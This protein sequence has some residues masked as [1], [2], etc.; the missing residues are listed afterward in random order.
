M[1]D[2]DVLASDE[3]IER[4]AT[5]QDVEADNVSQMLTAWRDENA[6][7]DRWAVRAAKRLV[8]P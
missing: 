8:S 4:I 5:G 1:S 2:A 6:G 3:L 7:P